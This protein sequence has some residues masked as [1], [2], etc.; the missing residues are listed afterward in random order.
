MYCTDG[1]KPAVRE[2]GNVRMT[3]ED[4]DVYEIELIDGKKVKATKEH[5]ILTQ[6]GWVM[7]KDLRTDDKVACIGGIYEKNCLQRRQK[8]SLL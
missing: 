8:N 4:A 1:K 5:P 7:V 6:R 3:Q 2:F